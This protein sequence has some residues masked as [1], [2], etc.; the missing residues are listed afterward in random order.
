VHV[1]RFP[2]TPQLRFEDAV[3]GTDPESR[4]KTGGPF[5]DR[6]PFTG[7]GFVP[8][9]SALVPLYWL[10]HSRIP[11]G[12]ELIRVTADGATRVVARFVDVAQGWQSDVQPVTPPGSPQVS[13]FVG[14]LAVWGATPYSADPLDDGRVVL[15]V[16]TEPDASHGFERTGTGRWRRVVPAT[17]VTELFE[18]SVMA[19]WNGLEMRVVDSFR[20]AEGKPIAHVSYTG[21]DADLAEGLGLQKVDA[22]VY[23]ASVPMASLVD[24]QTVQ[25][26]P[27]SWER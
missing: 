17:E 12:S 27:R 10:V 15:A 20:S 5:I 24:V 4:A 18:M 1:L 11:A 9:R 19:R 3:G 2:A 6:P 26:I 14:P 8:V 22:A 25:L 7:L 16:E 21:H 13:R 23:E